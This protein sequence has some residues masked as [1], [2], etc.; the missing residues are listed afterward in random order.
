MSFLT[1][2]LAARIGEELMLGCSDIGLETEGSNFKVKFARAG[3]REEVRS[4][5]VIVSAPAFVASRLIASVSGEISR[6]MDEIEYPPLSIVYLSYDRHQVQHSLDGFGFLA[7]PGEGL[8]VLGS[9]WNSSLF[10]GRAPQG[11]VLLT[12]FV[13]GARAPELARMADD[14]I[15]AVA[16]SELRRV[17]GISGEPHSVGITHYERA[18]PQYNL[19]HAAR[20]KRIDE[21]LRETSGLFLAGN[22]LRGVSTGDCVKEADRVARE[23]AAAI[24]ARQAAGFH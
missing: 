2:T 10:E 20:V 13:G 5:S 6:L 3:N 19:G 11:K 9:V 16:H 8:K 22:Y 21:I 23:A 1:D 4:R 18:I 24:S 14:E 17:L 12:V 7:A 15:V